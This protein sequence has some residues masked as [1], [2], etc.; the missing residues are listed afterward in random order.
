[1]SKGSPGLDRFFRLAESGSNWRREVLA[2]TTTFLAMAYI[3]LVNPFMLGEEA[4]MDFGAVFVATAV[5]SAIGTLLMGL[6]ANYPIALAPGM[7]LNAYFT[8]TVVQGM[9][10]PWQT[11]LGAVFISGVIFLLLTAT[12]IRETIINVI[13][14]GMKHAVSAGIGLFI[15]FIGLKNAQIIIGS[16]ATFVALNPDLM[17]KE[18]LLTLFGLVVTVLLMIRRVRGAVLIGMVVTALVGVISGAVAAPKGIFSAPPSIA[19][20]FLKMDIAGALDIG[21]FTVIFA[22]LFVDLFDTA[23]TLVGVSSQAGLLKD[24]KLPR[25]GRALT[26]DSLATMAGAAMGTST[27]TSYIESSAGVAAGGRTGLTAV[28]TAGWFLVALFFLPP[29]GVL[30]FGGGD[31]FAGAD[32]RGRPDG[33]KFAGNRLEGLVGGGA[34]FFDGLDDAPV[35]QHRHRDCHRLYPVPHR[36]NFCRQGA[37]GASHHVRPVGVVYHPVCL[38]GGHLRGI[39]P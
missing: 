20:T 38:P 28:T 7:G 15:A 23:G 33:R 6:L 3:L 8:Y 32:H 24:N 14:A 25:A 30:R 12:R 11:A 5:A 9:G 4:G 17:Q 18:I 16:E 19:P 29:G 37:S 36:Q 31:H 22:F 34:G 13:P 1:M 35:L 21:L 2:G 26:A 10:V 27:V 39:K